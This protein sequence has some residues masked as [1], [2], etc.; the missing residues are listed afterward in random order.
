MTGKKP[1]DGDF[2]DALEQGLA[3]SV[4]EIDA[5]TAAR[6]HRARMAA[7]ERID[8]RRPVVRRWLPAGI[9]ATAA[10][11]LVVAGLYFHRAAPPPDAVEDLELLSSSEAL[12]FYEDLEFYE[13]L[14]RDDSLG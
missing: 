5:A 8:S 14:E 11:G 2:P 4:E 6:L 9:V 13:W 10:V 1:S 3:R 7:L 12:D